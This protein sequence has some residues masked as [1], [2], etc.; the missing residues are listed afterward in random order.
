LNS[1]TAPASGGTSWDTT[2]PPGFQICGSTAGGLTSSGADEF[3]KVTDDNRYD[4][5][6][7]VATTASATTTISHMVALRPLATGDVIR[8]APSCDSEANASSLVLSKPPLAVR[9]DVIVAHITAATPAAN[10]VAPSG[11]TEVDRRDLSPTMSSLVYTKSIEAVEPANW[12]WRFGT[13]T[14]DIAG[15]IVGYTN[16]STTSPVATHAV[17]TNPCG[18]ELP[19][20][21][22][23]TADRTAVSTVGYFFETAGEEHQL[24]RHACTDSGVESKQLLARQLQATSAVTV[25]CNPITCDPLP[26]S[27]AITLREPPLS[28]ETDGRSY[29]LSARTRTG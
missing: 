15:G 12:T 19:L 29:V 13:G 26:A 24:V 10:V 4:T 17:T 9:G 27:A 1:V 18:G 28:Y 11:W 7:R 16:I 5:L 22:I 20:L 8:R 21:S 23:A 3:L 14:H 6:A 2:N 25:A